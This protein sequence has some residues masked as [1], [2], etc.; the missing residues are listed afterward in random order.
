MRIV[1]VVPFLNEARYLPRFLAS[2]AAQTRP[3]DQLILV[4]DGSRDGSGEIAREFASEHP[5]VL[6]LPR[7]PRPPRRDRLAMA[8]ELQAFLW[9]V[10]H[11][12]EP[13]D[14]VAKLDA[15]LELPA[16][17]IAFLAQRL[18][19]DPRLGL[20]GTYLTEEDAHG[21]RTRLRIRPEHVHG[22][23]KFYRR[24]CFEDIAPL[25]PTLGW[26]TLDE[27]TARVRGWRTQSFAIPGG[28]PLHLRPRASYD[29]VARGFRRSGEGAWAIGHHPLHVLL[30]G[31]RHMTEAPGVSG[32]L[33][34]LAGW[35]LAG[36]RRLPRG[37]D[38]EVLEYIR[39]DE[40]ARI[41]QRMLAAARGARSPAVS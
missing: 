35:S 31:L 32:G 15:D 39:Q 14:V 12:A 30:Y 28:D 22:A 20:A 24:A 27:V 8:E 37:A 25:P 29:G 38:P 18:A 3:L 9:G 21:H 7:P 11:V 19:E 36:L 26:D 40:L 41:R 23:T 10:G 17:T 16:G 1:A 34:Y 33:N 2:L 6:A 13:W 5:S 4:D